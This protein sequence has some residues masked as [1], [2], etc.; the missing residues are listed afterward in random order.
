[1]NFLA[2]LA[3]P[4]QQD[5]E[6]EDVE[7]FTFDEFSRDFDWAQGQPGR[8][9][10]RPQ[11]ARLAQRRLHPRARG[12][13]VRARGCC[14]T[15]SARRASSATTQSL[16]ELA[17]LEA[18]H[19]ADPDPDGPADRGAGAGRG[20]FFV[21]DDAARHRRRRPRPAQGRRPG[22]ARRGP[23]R[24]SATSTTTAPAC[25]ARQR[26]ERRRHRGGAARRDRRRARHQAA[27][28]PSARCAPPSRARGSVPPLFESMEIL[29]KTSTLNRLRS[30]RDSL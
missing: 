5:A 20:P 22:G 27:S 30:L 12:R 8:P 6:G 23:R 29:G 28:S 7:V 16:G 3:Y 15:S 9:D 13:R 26:L 18:G 2:L 1:M 17:R 10:L 19:R 25:S 11:E 21:A 4:P 24:C 14:P